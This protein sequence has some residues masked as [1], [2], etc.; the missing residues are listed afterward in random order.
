MRFISVLIVVLSCLCGLAIGGESGSTEGVV[1][2]TATFTE[3]R[4]KC[5]GVRCWF[6][7]VETVSRGNG[8]ILGK[9]R[10]GD[11]IIATA[12]HVVDRSVVDNLKFSLSGESL[13]ATAGRASRPGDGSRVSGPVVRVGC[14]G[15]WYAARVALDQHSENID[16]AILE[17]RIPDR[18]GVVH[19]ADA[20]PGQHVWFNGWLKDRGWLSR[21]GRVA[22]DPRWLELSP[23]FIDGE[24]GGPVWDANGN[25]VGIAGARDY[26]KLSWMTGSAVIREW[27]PSISKAV[28]DSTCYRPA[29]PSPLPSSPTPLVP[30]PETEPLPVAGPQVIVQQ[31]PQGERGPKGDRGERGEQ[32]P[33]GRTG[34]QGPPGR[35]GERGMQGLT[36][37]RGEPGPQGRTGERGPQG[38]PGPPGNTLLIDKLEKRVSALEAELKNFKGTI[39]VNVGANRVP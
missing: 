31:G 29:S 8:V 33:Q 11:A 18:F 36:G 39:R 38:P 16:L 13:I 9:T 17:A 4:Q 19:L 10:D 35:T 22:N 24:S 6:E 15:A 28:S 3:N 37:L 2:V 1:A 5:D 30:I 32:G 34:D 12:S 23:S 25:L 7:Q 20:Q 27:L 21:E 26:G 14:N